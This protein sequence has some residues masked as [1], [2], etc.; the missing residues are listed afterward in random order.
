[1]K[2]LK[3]IAEHSV[4]Y[5]RGVIE[6]VGEVTYLPS[7][8]FT[9]ETVRDADWLIIR[10]ITK[11]SRELLTGSRVRLIT[12]ATIGFDHIDTEYCDAAG[13]TWLNAPGCNAEAVGQ[14]FA[15]VISALVVE[16]GFDPKGKVLGIVGVGHVGTV[17][18]RYAEAF[19]MTC[20]LNDPP[21]AEREGGDA[22][23]SLEEIAAQADI[24]TLHTPLTKSGAHPTYHLFDKALV[25]RLERKPIV[26]NA[27]RG[28]VTE[29]E[30]L[31][32]GLATRKID[33]VIIDC[34]EG[35]PHIST[36][37]LD[38][39]FIGTPHIAGFSADGK[40]N[41]ARMCVEAGM[42]FFGIDRPDVLAP[43]CPPAPPQPEI[44][45][46]LSG[47]NAFFEAILKTFDP[48]KVDG[49]L[50]RG[51]TDFEHLRKTYDYPREPHAYT[52]VRATEEQRKAFARI[53]P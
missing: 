19:G 49:D 20:L 17:V 30:A 12:T 1:M 46:S 37:L 27:C 28:G 4:P 39:A 5:L 29:T 13:I 22:F 3:I 32:D 36:T 34:W 26:I 23:V 31:L 25:A 47:E 44:D 45:L 35:E 14:Y 24:I 40:A 43:M 42:K 16:T 52:L 8:D 6:Q 48:R 9:P 38:K 10:S 15:G 33:K 7:S 11:C 51:Y 53:L 21:R 2:P 18:K 50:R 41:G